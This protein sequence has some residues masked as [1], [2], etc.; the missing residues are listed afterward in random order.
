ML[1]GPVLAQL[2]HRVAAAPLQ[3]LSAQQPYLCAWV[4]DVL[5]SLNA[6]VDAKQLAV[7]RLSSE[8]CPWYE[9][10]MLQLWLLADDC[11]LDY[12]LAPSDLLQYLTHQG[13]VLAGVANAADYVQDDE[14]REELVR[15]TLQAL[16]L[17]P[18]GESE[19][20]AQERLWQVSSIE[21]EKMLAAS[22]KAEQR[23]AQIRQTLAQQRAREAADKMMRE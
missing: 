9:L 12:A 23:A 16:Q 10:T 18:D 21:R 5:W 2:M 11:W 14:R 17:L 4:H 6:P 1:S 22:A 15:L 20:I 8:H 3:A 19:A 7:F 13:P